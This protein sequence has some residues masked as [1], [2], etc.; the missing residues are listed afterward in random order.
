VKE[1]NPL[2]IPLLMDVTCYGCKR[3]VA[4]S[5]TKEHDGRRY[6][7]RCSGYYFSVEFLDNGKVSGRVFPMKNKFEKGLTVFFGLA[8]LW[9]LFVIAVIGGLIYVAVHFIQKYW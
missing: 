6:C 1:I 5:N 7:D 2:D 8:I 9:T 4:L 3:C